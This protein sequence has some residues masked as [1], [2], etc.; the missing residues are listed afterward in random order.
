MP[1]TVELFRQ[2]L[3]PWFVETG[4]WHGDGVQQALDAG[5]PRVRSIE[6]S[7]ALHAAAARRFAGDPRVRLYEGDSSR[8]LGEMIADVRTPI[9][10]WLDGHW[11]RGDTACGDVPCPVLAELAQ[12]ARH[13]VKVHTILIDDVRLFRTEAEGFPPLDTV[14]AALR[15]VNS[16]YRIDY[17]A[18]FSPEDIL[19][20]QA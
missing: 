18:G 11:S 10:F 7:S 15:A 12:I 17:V 4:T 13:P 6:L 5:F 9:T 16:A 8:A 2:H 19:V 3:R 20:A 1:A 14:V